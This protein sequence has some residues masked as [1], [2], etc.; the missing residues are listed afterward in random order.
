[1]TQK[2]KGWVQKKTVQDPKMKREEKKT[3]SLLEKNKLE[4]NEDEENPQSFKNLHKV[5]VKK[6]ILTPDP[7]Y[8]RDKDQE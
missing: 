8:L 4:T 7:I 2:E 6:G 3:K 5:M 1:L